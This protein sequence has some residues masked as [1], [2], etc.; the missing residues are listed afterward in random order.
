MYLTISSL[1]LCIIACTVHFTVAVPV[2]PADNCSPI[3][4]QL[5]NS[6]TTTPT[7][8]PPDP[9]TS[10]KLE[11]VQL[12]NLTDRI[13]SK[14]RLLIDN[15]STVFNH[16]NLSSIAGNYTAW[17][18]DQNSEDHRTILSLSVNRMKCIVRILVNV[19]KTESLRYLVSEEPN[20]AQEFQSILK[21]S[22]VL[23]DLQ[24]LV[25]GDSRITP[26]CDSQPPRSTTVV[27]ECIN[28]DDLE[29]EREV[30]I[31]SIASEVK[32]L[33]ASIQEALNDL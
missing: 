17:I 20:F 30:Q 10:C 2:P 3:I 29:L 16:D 12:D 14:I 32:T 33:M 6:T 23:L 24:E 31:K 15:A 7:T 8:S 9:V 28:F 25:R 27:H 4:P 1:L 5:E 13:R 26:R 11:Q 18:R 22:N 19:V 21:N